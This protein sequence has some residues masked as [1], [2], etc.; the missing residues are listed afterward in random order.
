MAMYLK[1]IKKNNNLTLRDVKDGYL[2][3]FLKV[4]P[5]FQFSGKKSKEFNR[6]EIEHFRLNDHS[7]IE[8]INR[9]EDKINTES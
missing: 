1:S 4:E 3:N 5:L 6:I 8:L 9:I 7:D 2:I